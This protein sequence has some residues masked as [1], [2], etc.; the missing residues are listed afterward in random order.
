MKIKR[1][2]IYC[3]NCGKEL[4]SMTQGCSCLNKKKKVKWNSPPYKRR[5]LK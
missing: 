2:K 4:G 3:N 1:N 5:C